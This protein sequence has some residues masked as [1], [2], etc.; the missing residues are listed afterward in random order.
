MRRTCHIFS[1]LLVL[2]VFAGI[3]FAQP[4]KVLVINSYHAEYPWVVDHNT[5]LKKTLGD[6]A[7]LTF[8]YMDTKRLPKGE[9]M[10]MADRAM[11]AYEAEK[12]DVVVL[13]DDNALMALGK[14]VTAKGTPV[15]Y[16]G[17][18]N[19]P[20][21]YLGKML[22]AT[23]VL[24]RPL[25]KRSIVYLNDILG[26]DLQKCLVLFDDGTTAHTLKA[27]VFQ[28]RDSLSFANTVTDIRCIK[29]L[30]DWERTVLSAK[31]KGY[32]A[33][34]L[35]LYHTLTDQDGNPVDSEE[36]AMWTSENSPVPL[37]GFWD[38][39]IGKGKAIGGLVLAGEPQGREAGKLV[40]RILSGEDPHNVQ[41]VTAEH[42]RFV[43]SNHELQRWNIELPGYFKNPS[44]SIIYIE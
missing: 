35:G 15:V 4:Q 3:A 39:T 44:E 43:F 16:L 26:G 1:C 9:H 25:L 40:L 14:R 22:L 34:I 30:D 33:V 12:P 10:E 5:A 18:N 2:I 38:F 36:V 27:E 21:K 17:I 8:F 11:A 19:N 7:H 6:T 28:E 20:R 23:G 37:F 13:T 42:G 24:E 31:E 32:D 29:H 41:P